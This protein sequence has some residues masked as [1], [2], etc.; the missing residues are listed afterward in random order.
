MDLSMRCCCLALLLLGVIHSYQA[1]NCPAQQTD[2]SNTTVYIADPD[3]CRNYTICSYEV[4]Y[5]SDNLYKCT[6]QEKKQC[7]QDQCF[8]KKNNVCAYLDDD[9]CKGNDYLPDCNDCSRYWQCSNGKKVHMICPNSLWFNYDKMECDYVRNYPIQS[10]CGDKR[11]TEGPDMKKYRVKDDDQLFVWCINKMAFLYTC[12]TY[13]NDYIFDYDGQKCVQ[14]AR[15]DNSIVKDRIRRKVNNA[16]D[17]NT[18]PNICQKPPQMDD[19]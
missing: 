2:L 11:C 10:G 6:K 12:T 4:S 1:Q 14:T 5:D 19:Y 13:G 7:P 9:D 3:E 17:G 16:D 15:M 18:H 8:D